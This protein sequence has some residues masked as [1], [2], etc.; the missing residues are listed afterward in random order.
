MSQR[1]RSS[2]TTAVV[3][4]LVGALAMTGLVWISIWAV[5]EL[6]IHVGAWA[7][8]LIGLVLLVP[9]AVVVLTRV[10]RARST[11]EPSDAFSQAAA[12][13]RAAA[14][15]PRYRAMSEEAP[16]SDHGPDIA[17]AAMAFVRKS[18]FTALALGAVAGLV[19]ARSPGVLSR[20]LD[21][22]DDTRVN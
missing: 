2:L 12:A 13:P 7:P 9:F 19:L 14:A 11:L 20:L 4:L 6:R 5:F 21:A 3:W 8:L 15:P 1:V 16:I 18:P 17:G 10:L 22:F